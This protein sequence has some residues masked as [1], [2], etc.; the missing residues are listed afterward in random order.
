MVSEGAQKLLAAQYLR[1]IV[2]WDGIGSTRTRRPV[3]VLV[4]FDGRGD[5]WPRGFG[6]RGTKRF[7]WV[8]CVLQIS[9]FRSVPLIHLDVPPAAGGES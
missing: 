1:L 3:S 6:V 8:F 7:R 9:C 4:G 5:V 2:W